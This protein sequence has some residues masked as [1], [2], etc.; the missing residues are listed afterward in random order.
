MADQHPHGYTDTPVLPHVD[1]RVHDAERPHPDP[2]DPGPAALPMGPPDDA[3]VLLGAEDPSLDGWRDPD[4]GPAGWI[5]HDDSVEVEP[6]SGDIHTADPIGNCQL[7]VEWRTP[8]NAASGQ[9]A[10][11]SGVFL[12]DRY[13]IQVLNNYENPTYADGFAGAVYGQHPPAVNA[14]R[15]PLE[16]QSYD[17]LWHG[18]RFVDG[19]Q[20]ERPRV[21]VFHNGVLVQDDTELLG[22]TAH[23][24]LPTV[25]PHPPEAPLRLQDHGDRVRF[26]NVWYRP[27]DD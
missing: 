5:E 17:I 14:S 8:D 7:H 18:P 3:T 12:M 1:Y 10:G 4:D 27:L 19:E 11:N 23:Q 24:E 20:V 22:P 25:E 13:E 26:R 21:T 2:V 15:P 9:G 6:G 16:W